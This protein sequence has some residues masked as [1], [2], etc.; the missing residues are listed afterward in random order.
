MQWKTGDEASFR[1]VLSQEDFNRF[2]ALRFASLPVA[3]RRCLTR[4]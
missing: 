3:A 1:R 2:A 4:A